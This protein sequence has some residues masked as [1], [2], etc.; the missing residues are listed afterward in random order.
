MTP[1]KYNSKHWASLEHLQLSEIDLYVSQVNTIKNT[2]NVHTF[3]S[4]VEF[5]ES[6]MLPSVEKFLVRPDENVLGS[7]LIY[8]LEVWQHG[9]NLQASQGETV[10]MSA[11]CLVYWIEISC[12]N[13]LKYEEGGKNN[14]SKPI[15]KQPSSNVT[16]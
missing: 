4:D 2:T 7:L 13:L 16:E 8:K 3:S 12:M 14:S 15:F 1:C 10:V 5:G 9:N 6:M 11:T